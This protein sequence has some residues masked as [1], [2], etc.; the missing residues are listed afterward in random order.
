MNNFESLDWAL[1]RLALMQ[2]HVLDALRLQA[3]NAID[4][5][6]MPP[7][8][9][10]SAVCAQLELQAPKPLSAPDVAHLPLICMLANGNWGVII[11]TEPSGDWRVVSD[12]VEV[13]LASGALGACIARVRC[14]ALDLE[15][16]E[17][18][19]ADD[20]D[21][22][23]GFRRQFDRAF[24]PYRGTLAEACLASAVIGL[25]A[26][27]TSL[28]SMQVYDR[29]IPTRGEY[30]LFVLAGG[31]LLSVIIELAMKYARSSLMDHVVVGVDSRLSREI[32]Q[33]LL[34]L[35]LDQ[36]PGSVGSLAAQIR[37]YEQVRGFYTASSLF[38]LI[39]LPMAVLFLGVVMLL[40]TPLVALVLLLFAVVALVIGISARKQVAR[41]ARSGAA[42]SN[43]KT[44]LLVEAIEGAETIKAGSGG[45]RFLSRWLHVNGCSIENDLKMRHA[46]ENTGYLAATVQQLSYA[47]LIVAGAI[48]VM[49]G[50]MST[51]ALIA[52]SILSG[53][54]LTPILALPGLMVQHA[55]ARAAEEG[56]EKLYQL[57]TD[58]H[59]VRKP[60]APEHIEGRYVFEDVAFSYGKNPL[61]LRIPRLHIQPGERIAVLGPIGSG[62][63]TLLRL[64]A[65]LYVPQS[66]RVLLDGLD[67]SHISRLVISRKVGYLQQE[68]RLFQGTLRENL[69]IGLP[70]PGDE[71]LLQAMRRSGMDRIVAAHP[72]GLDRPISEGGKGLSGGQQQLMAFTRLLLC[73]PGIMLLDEPT[74]AM[75][76]E[77]ERRCLSVLAEEAKA[78]A[79]L[80]V[81]THKPSVLPLVNR[82]IV[83]VGNAIVMDGPR[84]AV[85]QQLD[86]KR[87]TVPKAQ[88]NEALNAQGADV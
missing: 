69:L 47:A 19:Q 35:R 22:T 51:G 78:G 31:V 8:D 50:Q 60:L 10:L 68:H 12:S 29:V 33:R 46:S 86:A 53:R 18:A 77:Q 5:S 85:L 6:D 63:S 37:G 54:I 56:L 76:E 38:A 64:L 39:D 30:T 25:L 24:R 32:F 66:G 15:D 81:V 62:K 58:N 11:D 80:V 4:A 82:I 13:V 67:L 26:L 79:T 16:P 34:R 84:D 59:G 88:S 61:A 14:A 2:G 36:L 44:G 41:H 83:I 73:K 49:Q 27:A 45:W 87:K 75:D 65:G 3:C 57:Q 20:D 28:F 23:G 7:F 48:M 70:D 74:A 1:Q 55:H 21:A 42:Y 52:C 43:L 72:K 9:Y 17:Y 40:A 71:V